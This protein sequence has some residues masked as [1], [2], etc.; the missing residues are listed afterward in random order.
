VYEGAYYQSESPSA[1]CNESGV[2]SNKCGRGDD[3]RFHAVS[4][5]S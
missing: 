3:G 1:H 4:G 2:E 5:W